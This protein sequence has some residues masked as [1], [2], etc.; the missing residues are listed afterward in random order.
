MAL[1]KE[2]INLATADFAN[3]RLVAS[4]GAGHR[5]NRAALDGRY[6]VSIAIERTSGRRSRS[7]RN[8]HFS[9][10]DFH[11]VDALIRLQWSPEQVSGHL[12][13]AQLLSISHET[14]LPPYLARPAL[15][16][17]PA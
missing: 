8:Q 16:R 2:S 1:Q 9:A 14:N 4:E 15:R 13:R 17:P 5:R 3:Q 11:R 6:R 12:R 10:Q 7:R